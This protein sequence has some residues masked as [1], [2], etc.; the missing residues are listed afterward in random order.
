MQGSPAWVYAIGFLAQAFFSA[1]L[2][3]QWIVTEKAKKVLSPAAFWILSIFGSYLLFIYGV[4]R[5][6]FAIILGQFISYYIFVEPRSERALEGPPF[7][8]KIHS[9]AHPPRSYVFPDAGYSGLCRRIFSEQECSFLVVG[10]RFCRPGP[11]YFPV[12]L[13]M[14]IFD[15]SS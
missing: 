1:R 3:Y 9:V 13:S 14:D 4:L 7:C 8:I 12:Y 11:V 6:D 5:N 2:L 15:T 10:L